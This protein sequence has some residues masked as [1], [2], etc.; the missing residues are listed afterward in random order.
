MLIWREFIKLFS[1]STTG[2][3]IYH[4]HKCLNATNCL[5]YHILAVSVH[6]MYNST[7]Q[8]GGPVLE[9]H[10]QGRIVPSC[11]QHYGIEQPVKKKYSFN[12]YPLKSVYGK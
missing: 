9:H 11:L 10:P 5:I 12:S 6:E 7:D 1:C 3:K 4:A 2:Y 8:L